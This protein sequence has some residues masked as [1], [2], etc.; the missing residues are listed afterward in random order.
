MKLLNLFN[1]Y[2]TAAIDA[3]DT[4]L[5]LE[6]VT[7]I[8]TAPFHAILGAGT[9]D[10]EV[11]RVTAVT[12]ATKTL[13]IV[14]AQGGTTGVAHGDNCLFHHCELGSVN[15]HLDALA[16][17]M[18][19]STALDAMKLT[20]TD[21]T[22]QA[23]G[24]SRGLVVDYTQSGTKTVNAEVN[25]IAIDMLL[26]ADVPY[27]YGFVFYAYDSGD[28]TIGF[29]A[30]ISI[31]IDDCGSA[32][33][34]ICAIDVGL[35]TGSNSPTGRH[36]FMRVRNHSAGAVPDAIFQ[37]EGLNA[38][39]NLFRFENAAGNGCVVASGLTVATGD[40]PYLAIEVN[41]VAY[42]IAIVAI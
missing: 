34:A 15:I 40:S 9:E 25:G 6:S 35:A 30:A 22:T 33:G 42:G 28:P 4:S 17:T 12:T 41:D 10:E 5:V 27:A 26:S 21:T 13:T 36:C 39:D 3:D 1:S 23:T 11:V 8:P 32:V 20:V 7:S 29:L 38:A 18:S 14:R 16:V 2:I 24:L 19:G 37:I 31:Y